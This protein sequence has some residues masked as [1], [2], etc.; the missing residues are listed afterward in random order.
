MI[1]ILLL[2]RKLLHSSFFSCCLLGDCSCS[3]L[4]K[5]QELNATAAVLKECRHIQKI[6]KSKKTVQTVEDNLGEKLEWALGTDRTG[7]RI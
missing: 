5:Y 6:I 2:W 4:H 3:S 7:L 1:H